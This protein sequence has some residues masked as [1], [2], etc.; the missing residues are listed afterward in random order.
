MQFAAEVIFASETF[1]PIAILGGLL[2]Y[3]RFPLAR[4]VR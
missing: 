1:G 3:P 2:F 4:A